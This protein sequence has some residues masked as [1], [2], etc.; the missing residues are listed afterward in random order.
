[1]TSILDHHQNLGNLF[2]VTSQ[3]A[4]NVGRLDCYCRQLIN[5]RNIYLMLIEVKQT[6]EISIFMQVFIL[7]PWNKDNQ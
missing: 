1:M 6:K 7:R 5:A 3:P 4:H 2:L